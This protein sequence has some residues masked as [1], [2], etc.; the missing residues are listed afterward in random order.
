MTVVQHTFKL[1]ISVHV[2]FLI[3]IFFS[4]NVLAD[5]PKLLAQGDQNRLMGDYSLAEKAYT[6]ALAK[7]PKNY[8]ILKSLVEVKVELKKYTEAKPLAEKILSRK[9]MMQKKVKV[10][11]VG[12]SGALEGVISPETRTPYHMAELVDETVVTAQSGKTNMRNYLDNK[13]KAKTPH[14]RLFF[15]SVWENETGPKK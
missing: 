11:V 2:I 10:F 15:F 9:V 1:L 6:E 5:V 8:R 12:Q 3:V 14:Y 7:E 4:G 13:A